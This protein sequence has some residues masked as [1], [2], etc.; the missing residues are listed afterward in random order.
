MKTLLSRRRVLKGMLNGSA[1]TVGLP[2]LDCFLNNNGTAFANG[3][4]LPL[5]YGTWF[6]GLGIAKN[7][8]V[9]KK[10]GADYDLPDEIAPLAPVKDKINVFTGIRRLQGRR[11]QH[12]SLHR[13]GSYK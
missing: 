2:L 11:S 8:F 1:V 13:L 9:P 3:E 5:R 4:P 12:V 7:A 6:W 10:I